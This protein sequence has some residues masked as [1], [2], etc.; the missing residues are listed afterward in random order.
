MKSVH[1]S[2][3]PR[4]FRISGTGASSSL[5][6]EGEA[7]P[8]PGCSGSGATPTTRIGF[9]VWRGGF[10]GFFFETILDT[11]GIND[12]LGENGRPKMEDLIGKRWETDERQN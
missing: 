2:A 7:M 10:R 11:M 8:R 6:V 9:L 5:P 1:V 12:D 3:L 4:A